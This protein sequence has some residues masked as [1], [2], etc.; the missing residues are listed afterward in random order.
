MTER[1]TELAAIAGEAYI[2]L[3][4]LVTMELTRLQAT[5]LE[6]GQVPGRGPM[7]HFSHIRAYPD[8]DFK[9]VVRPN[10][11]TLYSSGWLDLTDGPVIV[12]A[13]DT[14]GRY[15]MLPMLDMWTDV[16]ANPGQRASGTSAGDWAVVPPGWI[17]ELPDG[18]DRIGAPTPYVWVIGR[19]QTNGAEDYDAVHQVQDGYRIT[20]LSDWG[21]TV[22]RVPQ[23]IDPGVD[24]STPP[25][26][27]VNGMS[28]PA[29]FTRAA[30]LLK[31]HP[32]HATD[33]SQVQ[34]MRSIGLV[35]GQSFDA[36]ALDAQTGAAVAAAPRTAQAALGAQISTLATVTNGW[37][38]N[39]N[40]IGV[41]GNFYAKRAIVSMMGL[42]ANPPED[43]VYPLLMG[44]AAGDPLDGSNDYVLHFEPG[45]LPPVSAF[46]SVTM[47]DGQGFQAA[48]ALDRFAL[49]DRDP[50]RY[51]D[52]GSLDLYLQHTDPGPDHQANWLPAPLGRLGVTMRLYGP[53]PIVLSG[54]WAP[55]PV[56]KST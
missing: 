30:E 44:D 13:P 28:G 7:N 26:D 47:Y 50:L 25:L 20:R 51:N 21:G 23:L 33:W 43:A 16:F 40:S 45:G 22:T 53:E 1:D 14:R 54:A 48:N 6:A 37:Q 55:P 19:T 39:T 34:R 35:P 27:L 5:N 17:G 12:S 4:P 31:V 52:D 18:L 49:G 15:Y 36:D 11:D 56:R 24:M 38:M 46:W 42:G 10:F 29:F 32:P 9:M 3:Y 8:A 41:Y 2:Y